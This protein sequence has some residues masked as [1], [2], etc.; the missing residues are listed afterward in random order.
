ME[1]EHNL[2]NFPVFYNLKDYSDSSLALGTTGLTEGLGS[3]S[4]THNLHPV[5]KLFMVQHI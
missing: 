3:D 2:T 4:S 5:E 1:K